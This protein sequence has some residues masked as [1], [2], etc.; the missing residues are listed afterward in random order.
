[1]GKNH[2][3]KMTQ[4]DP[5]SKISPAEWQR[6]RADYPPL[7]TLMRL[8]FPVTRE[9]YLELI[10]PDAGPVPEKIDAELE[11]SLPP[12]LRADHIQ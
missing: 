5:L 7:D 2:A 3:R 9:A 12:F 4:P 8:E 6:L 1:M 10:W 11:A